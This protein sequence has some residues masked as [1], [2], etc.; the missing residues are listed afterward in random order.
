MANAYVTSQVYEM[1]TWDREGYWHVLRES[2]REN[3]LMGQIALAAG[4]PHV[5][6]HDY[7]MLAADSITQRLEFFGG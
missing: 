4:V 5:I 6:A 1:D 3:R 2:E 7:F